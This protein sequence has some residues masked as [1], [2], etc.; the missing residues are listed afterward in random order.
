MVH[1]P[2]YGV[3]VLER[4]SDDWRLIGYFAGLE[5]AEKTALSLRSSTTK[6]HVFY[7]FDYTMANRQSILS[8]S[9]A[10]TPAKHALTV[11]LA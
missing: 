8:R 4:D 9:I 11:A 10:S 2:Y 7:D 3:E 6:V 1:V 5:P